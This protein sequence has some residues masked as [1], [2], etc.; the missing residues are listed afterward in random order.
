M[1]A[2]AVSVGPAGRAAGA[3]TVGTCCL[4]MFMIAIDTTVVNLALP[5]SGG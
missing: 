2:P 4:S 1:R 3:A 5:L